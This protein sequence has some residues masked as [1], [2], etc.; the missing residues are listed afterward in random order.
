VAGDGLITVASAY[1]V[2]ETVD[3]LAAAAEA[4]GMQVFVRVNHAA[5]AAEVGMSLRP[6]ELILVGNPRGGTPLMQDR[7]TAGIDLP[8]RA[9]A[10]EDADGRVWLTTNDAAW[11]AD[12]HGLGKASAA[13]VSAVSAG[14]ARIV[15]EATGA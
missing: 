4:A 8:L 11:I 2:A 1:R 7:Q 3:R 9:L 15:G 5:G 13:A 6:T 12:R 14:L 10:W